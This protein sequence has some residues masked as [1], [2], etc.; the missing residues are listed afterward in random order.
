MSQPNG[1][2]R[3]DP[4]GVIAVGNSYA[5]HVA[6]Y[7]EA[8]RL[9]GLLRSTH[10]RAWGDD[11]LGDAFQKQFD[12]TM[13]S[14][15]SAVLGVLGYLEYAAVGLRASGEG[16]RQADEDATAAGRTIAEQFTKLPERV[17]A[18]EPVPDGQTPPAPRLAGRLEQGGFPLLAGRTEYA[19]NLLAGR[20][21]HAGNLLAGITER[22]GRL[23]QKPVAGETAA[24][25]PRLAAAGEH[26]EQ[27]APGTGRRHDRLPA[28]G[29]MRT[30]IL[31]AK[32]V[33]GAESGREDSRFPG[34]SAPAESTARPLISA[35]RMSVDDGLL[36]DG[37]PIPAGCELL[38]LTTFPD[39]TSRLDAN[40]YDSIVPLGD[41]RLT[42]ADGVPIA[43]ADHFF[44]VRPKADEV[45]DPTAP[46]YQPLLISFDAHGS[47]TPL[48]VD[49]G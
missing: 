6:H 5:A 19:G 49:R 34:S 29:P 25:T 33:V 21:E 32:P 43:S 8:L 20:T 48:I 38:T 12:G 22:A 47:A 39:G 36:V 13:D 41:R 42:T 24:P 7:H 40:P 35:H 14:V 3:V 16:Y 26:V 44:L 15:E 45:V 17:A 23:H 46:D 28:D 31:D 37:V 2:L 11:E 9:L 4:E 27:P 30:G 10:G 18:T 1:Y